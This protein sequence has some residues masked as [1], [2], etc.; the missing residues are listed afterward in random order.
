[1]DA[2]PRRWWPL[3]RA[4]LG[5]ALLAAVAYRFGRDLSRPELYLQPP[6]LGWLA[7]SGLLYLAALS[8]SALYWHRLLHRAGTSPPRLACLRAYFVSQLAKYIPGKAWTVVLRVALVRRHGV[9]AALGAVTTFVEVLTLMASGALLAALLFAIAGP[10]ADVGNLWPAVVDLVHLDLSP[11]HPIDRWP[12]VVLSLAFAAVTLGPL[13]PALFNRLVGKVAT[14]FGGAV[15]RLQTMWLLEGAVWAVPAWL[16]MGLATAC[17]F[18]ATPGSELPWTG[19]LF[20]R[21]TAV[22]GL[23]YVAG[24]L[25]GTP[26][27]LGVREFLLG[28]LLAPELADSAGG[29]P[30]RIAALVLVPV[31]L[32]RV[33][34]TAAEVVAAGLYFVPLRL[35]TPEAA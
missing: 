15:P 2:K 22:V 20:A 16:L 33:A 24:F 6:R 34:W 35:P 17:A 28:L 8:L 19:L 3:V 11:G 13:A 4:L 9:G 27:G 32:L 7:L 12:L 25:V 30:D 26:G 14:R 18:Q 21:L 5:L 10:T 1:M 23:S 31:L 29:D